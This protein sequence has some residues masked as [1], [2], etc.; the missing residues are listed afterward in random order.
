M[1]EGLKILIMRIMFAMMVVIGAMPV[2][3]YIRNFIDEGVT[4]GTFNTSYAP[5]VIPM[6]DSGV[7]MIYPITFIGIAAAVFH[8]YYRA[9]QKRQYES[10][11]QETQY[12]DPYN[13]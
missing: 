13:Q 2:Y 1:I 10:T 6:V 4:A 9:V 12:Y 11:Y 5:G 8:V 7:N 3:R